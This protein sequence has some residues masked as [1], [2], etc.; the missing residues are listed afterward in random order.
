[1]PRGVK[2]TKDNIV[3]S[4]HLTTN[5]LINGQKPLLNRGRVDSLQVN[6]IR[7]VNCRHF[8]NDT[9]KETITGRLPAKD[10]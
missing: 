9:A 10:K 2:C 3:N 5:R 4:S 7:L 6:L 1:M 8:T